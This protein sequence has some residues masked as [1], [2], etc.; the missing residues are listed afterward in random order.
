MDEQSLIQNHF[1]DYH[2]DVVGGNG[3]PGLGGGGGKGNGLSSAVAGGDPAATA[4]LAALTAASNH[5]FSPTSAAAASATAK[6]TAADLMKQPSSILHSTAHHNQVGNLCDA[7]MYRPEQK[8][9]SGGMNQDENLCFPACRRC[10]ECNLFTSNSY[11]LGSTFIRAL[12]K[13]NWAL[14]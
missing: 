5:N 4:S 9:S 11:N 13:M 3:Y 14:G 10:K 7:L 6:Q 8:I 2:A 12:Y 1:Q